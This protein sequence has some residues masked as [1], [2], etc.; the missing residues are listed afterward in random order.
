MLQRIGYDGPGDGHG[1]IPVRRSDR[2]N[3]DDLV[4]QM[5]TDDARGPALCRLVGCHC[6]RGRI[7]KAAAIAP[8]SDSDVVAAK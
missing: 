6:E 4:S 3:A 7:G 5:S 2:D 8:D 1:C